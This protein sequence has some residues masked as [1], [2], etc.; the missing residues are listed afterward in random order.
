[1]IETA[2]HSTGSMLLWDIGEYE[3]LQ[4]RGSPDDSDVDEPGHSS[5]VETFSGP[6]EVEKLHESFQQ[7]KIR[8]RLHGTR[9]PHVYT[10]ALRMTK[11]NFRSEQPKG[12]S[13]RRRRVEPKLSSRQESH[14]S[15]A[16]SSETPLFN[17]RRKEVASLHRTESPPSISAANAASGDESELIRHNNAYTGATNDIGSVHQ[18]KW[19]LA[20]DRQASG[21]KP[22]RDKKTGTRSWVRKKG[23]GGTLQGFEK[24]RVMG[25]DVERSVVSGRLASDILQDEG[26]V[27]YVP[28]VLWRPITE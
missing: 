3:V 20:L 22:V 8:L 27:G 6:K 11:E 12:P 26:V 5:Y 19:Y 4:Y 16:D 17:R 10:V 14:S 18:R 24:F 25:R 21:F 1:M 15:S 7:R 9:L 23:D 2:S 13:R 28:R